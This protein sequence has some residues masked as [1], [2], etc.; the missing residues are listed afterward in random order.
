MN[1]G[2]RRWREL[3]EKVKRRD[4]E[5]G[6]P[7]P[8][9]GHPLDWDAPPRSRW[10]PSVDHVIPRSRGGATL[11]PLHLLRTVHLSCNSARGDGTKRISRLKTSRDW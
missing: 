9:C 10:S 4:R 2:H 6:N 7:C 8:L 1:L 5:Q 11:P 3:A